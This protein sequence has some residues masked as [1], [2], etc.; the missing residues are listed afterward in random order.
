LHPN[1]N[2]RPAD[3]TTEGR[4]A[5]ASRT[6]LPQHRCAAAEALCKRRCQSG[7][8]AVRSFS[9]GVMWVV[10]TPYAGLT[11]CH[12]VPFKDLSV[13]KSGVPHRACLID[14]DKHLGGLSVRSGARTSGHRLFHTQSVHPPRGMCTN[15]RDGHTSVTPSQRNWMSPLST[16][17]ASS[18]RGH[19]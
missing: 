12:S 14:G 2:E 11:T 15:V 4:S 6:P 17:N 19:P 16:S 18:R 5:L 7:V 10:L 9:C 13:G 3:L 8:A 1:P